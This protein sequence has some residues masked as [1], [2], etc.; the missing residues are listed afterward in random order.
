M[1]PRTHACTTMEMGRNCV[2]MCRTVHEG[3]MH[4]GACQLPG[5]LVSACACNCPC[6]ETH[7]LSHTSGTMH[8]GRSTQAVPTRVIPMR[9]GGGW[10]VKGGG[11]DLD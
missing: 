1:V 9:G 4:E 6:I 2:T 11:K 3:T 7:D 5:L 8:E 10:G